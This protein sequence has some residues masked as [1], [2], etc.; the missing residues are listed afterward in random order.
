MFHNNKPTTAPKKE[1]LRGRG[2]SKER[3]PL[4]FHLA[5][6]LI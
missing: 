4:L 1:I 6:D 3:N 5:T 2:G